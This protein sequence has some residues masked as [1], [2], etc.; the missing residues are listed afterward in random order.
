MNQHFCPI[1]ATSKILADLTT[2]LII[3]ELL[4]GQKR[5][6]E[7]QEAMPSISSA[8]ISNR[9]KRLCNHGILARKQFSSIPP[10]VEYTL[11][12]L[13]LELKPIVENIVNFSNNSEFLK[14]LENCQS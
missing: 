7:L 5:F 10:K 6:N 14:K 12:N 11:T 8:T 9:L 3:R 1:L 2:I 4:S 13:G